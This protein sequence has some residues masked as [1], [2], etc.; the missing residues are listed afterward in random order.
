M[1]YMT[2]CPYVPPHPWNVD[3]PHLMLRAKAVK[4]KKGETTFSR[5]AA[6]QHRR[7]RQARLD[8][9]GGAG[10]QRGQ[11]D[12]GRAQGHGVGAGR[13]QGSRAAGVQQRTFPQTAPTGFLVSG[14]GRQEHAGQG[15]DLLDL[16]RELQ[17]ARHRPRSAEGSWRTTKCPAIVVEKEA[18]C[19]MPKLELG[20]LD[21][22]T[23]LKEIN[24][25]VLARLAKE[26]YA[27]L[28]G[29]AVLHADVQAGTAADVSG[30]CRRQGGAGGDVRS[31]R[32]PGH[33]G[34]RTA[35]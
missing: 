15:G 5:Q 30:R 1:C 25:P 13:A 4:F 7:R 2:K 21:A 35:C 14:Q 29:G 23:K 27:I 19:G 28:T 6:D 26:G 32:I 8:P 11:Q 9:G 18:C 22:V 17:R 16:L 10:R 12:H 34:T 20:D 33:C 3:F 31:V 24:I